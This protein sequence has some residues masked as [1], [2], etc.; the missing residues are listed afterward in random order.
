MARKIVAGNWKMNLNLEEG[1]KLIEQISEY[2]EST[3]LHQVEVV[4]ATPFIHLHKA[5]E[6][7]EGKKLSVA[8]Q[9]CSEKEGGAYTGEISVSML[10][11]VNTELVLVGH[12]ERR[13]Y[14]GDTNQVVNQKIKL[15]LK[16]GLSPIFCVGES[17]E[18]R[19]SGNHT[20]IVKQQIAEG[21]EGLAGTDIENIIIAYEPVWAI[22]TGETATPKQ[23]QEMHSFI[24]DLLAEMFNAAIAMDI[25]LLYGGSVKPDNAREI[26]SQPDVDGG[27]IGGA[28]L[29]A[30][31]F[32]ELIHIGSDVLR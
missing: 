16:E 30:D 11:S 23:A 14:Y 25:S 17:L 5:V 31:Q 29:K 8:A 9:N 1:V 22:G 20:S 13:L 4:A 12:S 3:N 10:K 24:R 15:L 32:N 6:M 27:L 2:C 7:A 19:K 21:L 18:D 28:S 26:F